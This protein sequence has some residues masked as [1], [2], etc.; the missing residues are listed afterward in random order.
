MSS[1][2]LD[3]LG[4]G[5]KH[6]IIA[7]YLQEYE[8]RTMIETG[9]YNGRGS[10]MAMLELGLIDDYYVIDFD[11]LNVSLANKIQ[12]VNAIYGDS[13]DELPGVLREVDRPALFWLDAHAWVGD[14]F[15]QNPPPS[16]LIAELVA[17][18]L[19]AHRHGSVVLIDDLRQM[20]HQSQAQPGWPSL[21]EITV[22]GGDVWNEEHLHDVLRF[23]PKREAPLGRGFSDDPLSDGPSGRLCDDEHLGDTEANR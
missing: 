12:A 18:R 21:A 9:L 1:V 3:P 13:A 22:A 7:G 5:S 23:T 6:H 19:W 4:A 8:L 20:R 10:G 14:E 17:I 16:P 2:N 11:Q 15:G